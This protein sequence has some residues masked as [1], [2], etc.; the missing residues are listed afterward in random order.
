MILRLAAALVLCVLA[1]P[2]FG[3]EPVAWKTGREAAVIEQRIDALLRQMTLDEKVGQLH[4]S[5]RGEG[6]NPARISEGRMGGVMNFVVPQ[7]VADVQR[8][9]RQSRLKIPLDAVHGFSTYFPLPLGQASTWNPELIEEA[10]YW[11]GREARAAGINWTF[12]PMVDISRD[13]RGGRAL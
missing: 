2:S 13:P 3:Q 12:A 10:A 11:T 4:L 8:A 7:E 6:F 9:V 1:A 5:G